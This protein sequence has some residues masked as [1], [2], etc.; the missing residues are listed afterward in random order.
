MVG[1]ELETVMQGAYASA[2]RVRTETAIGRRPVSIASAAV[3]LALDL[4]GDLGRC[5]GLLIGTGEMGELIAEA[6]RT[7]GLSELSVSHPVPERA[8]RLA[9]ALDCHEA[10]FAALDDALA[11]ADVVV[12][13][14]GTRQAVIDA[15]RVRLAL[16]ARRNRPV[17]LVDA[18]FP[19]DVDAAIEKIDSAFRYTL[20]D[21]ERIALESRS[22]REEEATDAWRI[23]DEELEAFMVGSAERAAAP[24]LNALRRRFEDTRAQALADAGG[25]AE[26][27]T[28]LLVSRLLHDPSRFLRSLAANGKSGEMTSIGSA[29]QRVFSLPSDDTKESRRER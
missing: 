28:R 11:A 7:A 22:R 9:R 14:L 20:E 10:P 8:E 3:E 5:R 24:V 21:L 16:R 26:K 1:G 18:A 17:F 2:K 25:D 6:L 23:V 27:A 12:C 13:A 29:L 19:G 4:H 15:D